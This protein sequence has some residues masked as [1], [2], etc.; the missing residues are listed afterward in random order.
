MISASPGFLCGSATAAGSSSVGRGSRL[1]G[2]RAVATSICL[3]PRLLVEIG[4]DDIAND[5]RG[6]SSRAR[7]SQ[8]APPPRSPAHCAGQS[9]RTR[10]CPSWTGP[11]PLLVLRYSFEASCAVPVLPH[12]SSPGS[13][14]WSPVPPLVHHAPTS[15]RPPWRRFRDPASPVRPGSGLRHSAG[16]AGARCRQSPARRWH[17]ASC[18]GVTVV[19]PWPMATEMVSPAYHF[20]R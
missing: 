18:S 15:R 19:A 14:A 3:V 16:A 12:T 20:C 9:R 13:R 11:S 6:A 1:G 5:G 10:H 2:N 8:T 17:D 4:L 7:R